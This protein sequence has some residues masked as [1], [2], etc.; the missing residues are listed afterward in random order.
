MSHLFHGKYVII[1]NNVYGNRKNAVT[2]LSERT[3]IKVTYTL[4]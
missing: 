3:I 1:K 2:T 4:W